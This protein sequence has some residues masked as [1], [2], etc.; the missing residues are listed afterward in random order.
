[1]AK[2]PPKPGNGD[3]H[4]KREEDHRIGAPAPDNVTPITAHPPHKPVVAVSNREDDDTPTAEDIERLSSAFSKMIAAELRGE[5]TSLD[6][7]VDAD[8]FLSRVDDRVMDAIKRHQKE[9]ELDLLNGTPSTQ[10]SK[11]AKL[12]HPTRLLDENKAYRQFVREGHYTFVGEASLFEKYR[13][14]H[15]QLDIDALETEFRRVDAEIRGLNDI[16]REELLFNFVNAVMGAEFGSFHSTYISETFHGVSDTA[17]A[18]LRDLASYYTVTREQSQTLNLAYDHVNA[19][20]DNAALAEVINLPYRKGEYPARVE[21]AHVSRVIRPEGYYV[22]LYLIRSLVAALP[23]K[24]A[25]VVEEAVEREHLDLHITTINTRLIQP[26]KYLRNAFIALSRGY[27]TFEAF[28]TALH[29]F[30]S[31]L[32]KE[33]NERVRLARLL[34]GLYDSLG[35]DISKTVSASAKRILADTEVGFF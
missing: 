32:S 34:V 28:F 29:H 27:G 5:D 8:Q 11:A 26:S 20:F 9:A 18:L 17:K 14:Y 30:Q 3:G 31:L 4:E 10:P 1:M 13:G 35:L 7:Y 24:T 16:I 21:Y 2:K 33:T 23:V 15:S 25:K 6:D 22:V 12:F 19:R